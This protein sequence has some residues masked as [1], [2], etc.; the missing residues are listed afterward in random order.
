QDAVN[1]SGRPAGGIRTLPSSAVLSR[2]FPFRARLSVHFI[3]LWHA[4]TDSE[5]RNPA[6]WLG[7]RGLALLH[8]ATPGRDAPGISAHPSRPSGSPFSDRALELPSGGPADRRGDHRTERILR[9]PRRPVG[10]SPRL[11]PGWS[12][13]IRV[14]GVRGAGALFEDLQSGG[15]LLSVR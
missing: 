15:F 6:F 8:A 14:P 13:Q 3:S 2:S 9:P 11:L 12:L 10:P 4:R 5:H 7:Q 1:R